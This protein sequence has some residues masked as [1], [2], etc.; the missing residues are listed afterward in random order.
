MTKI[1]LFTLKY[2]QYIPAALGG[3]DISVMFFH[4]YD[5]I[6]DEDYSYYRVY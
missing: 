2:K 1:D 3:G 6:A 4:G 5:F